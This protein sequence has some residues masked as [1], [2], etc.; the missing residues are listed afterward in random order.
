MEGL[1][2]LTSDDMVDEEDGSTDEDGEG[3]RRRGGSTDE[4][5]EGWRRRGGST[6]EDGEGWFY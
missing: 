1:P 2:A 3:W 6:D 5:G 4:D